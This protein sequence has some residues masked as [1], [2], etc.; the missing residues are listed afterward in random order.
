MRIELVPIGYVRG[1]RLESR[2]DG[3]DMETAHIDLDGARFAAEALIGIDSVSHVEVIFHL[4]GIDEDQAETGARHP[5]NRE[6]WPRV[7]IFAQRA[8]RRPNRIGATVCR[9]V[10][11]DGLRLSVA[12]LDAIDGTPVLDIKPYISGFAPR[13]DIVEP[14]WSREIMRDYW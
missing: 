11:V 12:G 1:S 6:D 4:H 3:W 10:G 14:D 5:R 9:V 2:D 8:S 7:G 13:G